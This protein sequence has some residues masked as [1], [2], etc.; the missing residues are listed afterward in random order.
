MITDETTR[1]TM[2]MIV[3]AIVTTKTEPRKN[4]KKNARTNHFFNHILINP[5]FSDRQ[6]KK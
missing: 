5:C 2:V 4:G 3:D 1:M 6:E